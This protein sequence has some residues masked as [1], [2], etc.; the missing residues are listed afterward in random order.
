M[1]PLRRTSSF[2]SS[3]GGL[4]WLRERPAD[5]TT[6]AQ[7]ADQVVAMAKLAAEKIGLKWRETNY[8]LLRRGPYIIAAG[9]DESIPGEPKVLHGRFVNLFDSELRV[10]ENVTL[11]P[12]SRYFLRDLNATKGG[13]L[14]LLASACK[15]LPVGGDDKTISYAVESVAG[16]PAVL[17][18]QTSQAPKSITLDGQPV[19]QT[20]FSKADKLLWIRF[21]NE[22]R[23]RT[24]E[25]NF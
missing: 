4:I 16:T 8:L 17:L 6:S 25:L 1:I 5:L 2:R 12:G 19:E 22:A 10:L 7:G 14:Q 3:K 13:K 15:V 11:A 18:F 9:L 21:E 24:L 20:E 23:P